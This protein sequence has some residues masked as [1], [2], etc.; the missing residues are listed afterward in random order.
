MNNN[1]NTSAIQHYASS[2]A[3]KITHQ[4]YQNAAFATGEHILKISPVAQVNYFVLKNLFTIWQAER[5]KLQSPY[6]DYSNKEVSTAL[7]NFLNL[8]SR[9]IAVKSDNLHGLLE[10]AVEQTLLLALNPV[11]FIEKELENIPADALNIHKLKE[12]N[13]YI[14][15]NKS[16]TDELIKQLDVFGENP[17]P[18]SKVVE[19]AQS[20]VHLS[21]A[22]LSEL[23]EQFS[24]V[25]PISLLDITIQPAM[26]QPVYQPIPIEMPVLDYFQDLL[27][28]T[29]K[30][31]EKTATT[32]QKIEPSITPSEKIQKEAYEYA[33]STDSAPLRMPVDED[34][35]SLAAHFSQQERT[36]TTLHDKIR[37]QQ[38]ATQKQPTLN[39]IIGSNN[40][41]IDSLKNAFSVNEK[42]SYIRD[43]FKED[44]IAWSMTLQELDHAQSL[45]E[46]EQ[47]IRQ[48]FAPQYGWDLQQ[49]RVKAFMNVLQK[50]F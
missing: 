49:E 13:R 47:L 31:V 27:K 29:E 33:P 35:K 43:L 1:I 17:I 41:K 22:N 15:L 26:R 23:L 28:E 24:Q 40:K 14:K 16:F 21:Q 44:N 34:L 50:R 6:F 4:F 30:E 36:T 5:E 46:A 2:F 10:K 9:H 37:E 48:K 20:L 12:I 7:Q 32:E 25:Q 39:E 42:Y 8:L 38:Q 45:Q 11:I 3:F 19:T 18:F